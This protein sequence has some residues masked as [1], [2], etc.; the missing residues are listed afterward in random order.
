MTRIGR[1]SADF[2]RRSV[3][4]RPIRVIRVLLFYNHLEFIG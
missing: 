2:L 3:K 1:I 4:I